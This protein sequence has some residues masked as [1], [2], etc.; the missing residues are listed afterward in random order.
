MKIINLGYNKLFGSSTRINRLQYLKGNI[1]LSVTMALIIEALNA[2]NSFMPSKALFGTLLIIA[3]ILVIYYCSRAFIG[4]LHD[5]GLS[6][7]YFFAILTIYNLVSWK[8][9]SFPLAIMIFWHTFAFI[10]PGNKHNNKY[11]AATGA[12]DKNKIFIA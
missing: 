5:I 3:L 7:W 1:I 4:R 2:L 9:P 12:T 11:G 8:Y 10:F 6:A